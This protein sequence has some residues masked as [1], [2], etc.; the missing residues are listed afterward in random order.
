MSD[1]KTLIIV[2]SPAK[3]RKISKILGDKFV[4][5]ASYGHVVDLSTDGFG[6]LGVDI[7]NDFTPKYIVIPD[8]KDKVKAI[9]AAAKGVDQ[10][11]A[12][13]DPD[14]EGEAIAWHL[15]EILKNTKLPI[16]RVTFDEITQKGIMK[17]IKAPRNINIDLF[18]AQQARRVLDRIV[19][20]SVSPFLIRKIGPKMSAGR[21][22][23]VA[24]RMV[25]DR[26]RE[27]EAFKPEEYWPISA[28]LAKSL[29]EESFS[30]KYINKVTNE[31]DALK[32]K[33]DL[34]NDKYKVFEVVEEQKPKKPNPPFIT[35]SLA[36]S[37]AGKYKFAAART[38]KAA[39]ALYEAGKITYIRTDSFRLSEDAVEECRLWLKENAY[40]IPDKSNI[41][42]T[43]KAAQDAHEAIR[44]TDVTLTPKNIFLPDDEQKIYTLVWERF[45]ACQMNP[46][47]YD[48]VNVTIKTSSDYLLKANGRT[49]KYKGWLEIMGDIDNDDSDVKLPILKKNDELILVSP[50]VKTE[51]KF[52]KPPPRF[53]EKTLI[54]ELE[55]RDIG[56]PS[57][58]ATI[59][60]KITQRSYVQKKSN[61]FFPT[62]CGKKIVDKL[63]DAF[64]FMDYNYTA[65]M[66][67]K[68][69]KIACGKLGY[70]EMLNGFYIPFKEE[71]K[72]AYS[73]DQK[74]YGFI[75]DKCKSKMVLRHSKFGF[76][77]ACS[78]YPKCN[79]TL[80][81]DMVGD[82]PIL[83]G[84][85]KPDLIDNIICPNCKSGMVKRDGKFGPFYA[86]V[87]YPK[88]KGTKKVPYGK[89]CT[90][91]GHEL[92]AAIY[93]NKNV[94]FCMNY[95]NC[96]H[97]EDLSD[98]EVANPNMV[99]SKKPPKKLKKMLK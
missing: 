71:L 42:A 7:D 26:E 80:S 74:D 66:E 78:G 62:D 72:K 84:T 58:Y 70:V 75:C 54:K 40:D 29:K 46:A 37:A 44:P 69:D 51:Q 38:M 41:Y 82:K 96:K 17:G 6:N 91:C 81:V 14:R 94:L 23:S 13:P 12:A 73:V 60:S 28:Q 57:T 16:F 24:V 97:K 27:I 1:I 79:R 11:Y 88:C 18:N 61:T 77:L 89:K 2:E 30:A 35:S 3:A 95:P 10:I 21:V 90:E 33:S 48:N 67:K 9:I 86:C 68:L 19:G 5:K 56:R 98:G 34:D 49:L 4:V 99:A 47:L 32:I 50:K 63:V 8:Q 39:Q 59:M 87:E 22:Q 45:V 36:S 43:K 53:T 20:F 65:D 25:V 83:R 76:F 85:L 64:C 52:T 92:Y 31:K 55:R 93:N 15:A